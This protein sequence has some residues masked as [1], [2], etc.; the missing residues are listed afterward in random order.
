MLNNDVCNFPH[1]PYTADYVF[2][3]SVLTLS[4][5]P[6]TIISYSSIRTVYPLVSHCYLAFPE[7]S[8]LQYCECVCLH[9]C[10]QI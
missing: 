5:V 6:S 8:L 4:P 1:V 2:Y 3:K 9:V 7:C 10:I